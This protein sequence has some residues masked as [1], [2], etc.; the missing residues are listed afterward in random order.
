MFCAS[1][2]SNGLFYEMRVFRY[3]GDKALGKKRLPLGCHNLALDHHLEDGQVTDPIIGISFGH[4]P[5]LHN[6]DRDCY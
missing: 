6:E 4:H 3:K 1:V 2:L 5:D